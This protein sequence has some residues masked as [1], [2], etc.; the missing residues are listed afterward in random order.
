[1]HVISRF[2]L[3][4]KSARA[5][6]TSTFFPM[7]EKL[8]AH[9]IFFVGSELWDSPS[10]SFSSFSIL[11]LQVYCETGQTCKCNPNINAGE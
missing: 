3:F 11:D 2:F 4:K 1:M 9:V 10:R 6:A 5:E 7:L 8:C